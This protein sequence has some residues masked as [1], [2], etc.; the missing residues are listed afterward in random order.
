MNVEIGTVAAHYFSG[1]ICFEFWYWFFAVYHGVAIH[2]EFFFSKDMLP[3]D[4]NLEITIL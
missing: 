2:V 3:D 4:S 1:N